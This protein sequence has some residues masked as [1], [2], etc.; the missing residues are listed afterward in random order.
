MDALN[1]LEIEA[2]LSSRLPNCIISC[3][4]SAD[5]TLS[6]DVTGPGSDQFTIVNIDRR[7]YQGE[8]GINK[9]AREILEEMVMSRQATRLFG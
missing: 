7:H 4:L 3:T 1:R 5:N 2:V 9:L 6:V 8:A